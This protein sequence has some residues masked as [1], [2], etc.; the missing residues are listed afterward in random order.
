M[1]EKGGKRTKEQSVASSYE[2]FVYLMMMIAKGLVEGMESIPNE[3]PKT[4][5]T[6]DRSS[7]APQRAR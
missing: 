5:N 3:Q 2:Q 6:L 7:D 4:V 1:Q